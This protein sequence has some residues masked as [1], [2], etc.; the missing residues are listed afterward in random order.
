MKLIP[1][2][3]FVKLLLKINSKE[4]YKDCFNWF[5][6]IIEVDCNI[7]DCMLREFITKEFSRENFDSIILL[8]SYSTPKTS[9][10]V[11]NLFHELKTH[12][13][14]VK[15]ITIELVKLKRDSKTNLLDFN[16]F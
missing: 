8:I 2:E 5:P 6:S 9:Q 13:I 1:V 10:E 15:L 16:A 12:K 14:L 3:E 4:F 7:L 11:L